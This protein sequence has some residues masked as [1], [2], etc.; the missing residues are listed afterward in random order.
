MRIDCKL[1]FWT[2]MEISGSA[3]SHV[4]YSLGTFGLGYIFCFKILKL[5]RELSSFWLSDSY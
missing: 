1:K 3:S 4:N 5:R 2:K